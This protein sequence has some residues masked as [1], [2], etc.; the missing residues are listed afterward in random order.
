M[1][2]LEA[3]RLDAAL[4]EYVLERDGGRCWVARW[5]G[6]DCTGDIHVH[7]IVPV[8]KGGTDDPD[9]LC[10]VCSRHHPMWE[11]LRQSVLNAR[12]PR[13]KRCPHRHTTRDGRVACERRMNTAA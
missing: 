8:S 9:N 12:G 3:H 2:T 5:L 10:A 13:W 7:H 11:R 4:R 1:Q 6:G